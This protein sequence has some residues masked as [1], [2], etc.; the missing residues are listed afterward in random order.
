MLFPDMQ[1]DFQA[2]GMVLVQRVDEDMQ[3]ADQEKPLVALEEK[4]CRIR[5][6]PPSL[7]GLYPDG[8]QQDAVRCSCAGLFG[9][10]VLS[11]RP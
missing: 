9:V 5:Q 4:A 1:F 2:V 8:G 11:A 3:A 6:M 10:L 7:V